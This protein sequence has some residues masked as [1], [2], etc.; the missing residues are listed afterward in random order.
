[1]KAKGSVLRNVGAERE[2]IWDP[3]RF[4]AR[5]VCIFSF[6][7][8]KDATSRRKINWIPDAASD[9]LI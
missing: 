3:L 9:M 1:M 4:L 8:I 2:V 5:D 6:N 7:V